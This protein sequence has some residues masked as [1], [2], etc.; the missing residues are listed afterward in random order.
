MKTTWQTY[1]I[2][3]T[4]ESSKEQIE[5]A[6]AILNKAV[7]EIEKLKICIDVTTDSGDF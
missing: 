5:I 1:T 7:L 3:W 6:E 4:S 2:G